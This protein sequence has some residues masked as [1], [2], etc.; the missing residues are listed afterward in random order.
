MKKTF[1]L[2]YYLVVA[3][4]FAVGYVSAKGVEN[5][6]DMAPLTLYVCHFDPADYAVL[7]TFTYDD[8]RKMSGPPVRVNIT[9]MEHEGGL[10]RTPETAAAM[11]LGL[12]SHPYYNADGVWYIPRFDIVIHDSIWVVSKSLVG[13]STVY[14]GSFKAEISM[15]TGE[16]TGMEC[17]K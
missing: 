13:P 10:V 17:Y 16:I 6:K 5:E 3:V 7:D 9:P 2:Y 8:Y 12:E 4:G 14:G 11:S 15:V 1:F